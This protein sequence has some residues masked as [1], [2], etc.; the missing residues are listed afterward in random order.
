MYRD[1]SNP[2]SGQNSAWTAEGDL[3]SKS[4]SRNR[5]RF[6][7]LVDLVYRI[8]ESA[9][10]DVMIVRFLVLSCTRPHI[11]YAPR[12]WDL[13][14]SETQ[15]KNK[16]YTYHTKSSGQ[17][18]ILRRPVWEPSSCLPWS[19]PLEAFCVILRR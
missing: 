10:P 5:V 18:F 8:E 6:F 17:N 3:L 13:G 15:T 2:R 11:S 9:M 4:N 14:K 19:A 7:H 1:L 12:K 16:I